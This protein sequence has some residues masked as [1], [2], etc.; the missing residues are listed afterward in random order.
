M[1]ECWRSCLNDLN[2]QPICGPLWTIVWSI[3]GQIVLSAEVIHTEPG[4]ERLMQLFSSHFCS[5]GPTLKMSP[6][7]QKLWHSPIR[8]DYCETWWQNTSSRACHFVSPNFLSR[9]GSVWY[10]L[11]ISWS[12]G[13]QLT[14]RPCKGDAFEI[15]IFMAKKQNA[16][17]CGTCQKKF[18]TWRFIS[19][20]GHVT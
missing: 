19:I 1:V 10:V 5:L 9:F 20:G 3:V 16:G 6:Y 4:P 17:I 18:A 14:R 12:G 8:K 11:D 15:E 2:D 13:D 7:K